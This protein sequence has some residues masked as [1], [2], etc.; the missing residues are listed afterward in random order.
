MSGERELIL[1]DAHVHL[2]PCFAISPF[3]EGAHESFK[4]AA[5]SYSSDVPFVGVLCFTDS[6]QS[7]GF[8]RLIDYCK[9]RGIDEERWKGWG[10]QPTMESTSVCLIAREDQTGNALIG[11]AG[12]QIVSQEHLEVLAIGTDEQFA[13]D[14]PITDV[15]CDIAQAGAIPIIPWGVGKWWNT[16]GRIIERLVQRTDLPDFF[17]G[18]SGN[19][20]AFWPQPSQFRQARALGIKNLPGSDPLPVRSDI[21]RVGSFGFALEGPLDWDRPVHDLKEKLL[22]PRTAVRPYGERESALRFVRNQV[23]MQ[24]HKLVGP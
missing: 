5:C 8:S 19:R 10:V 17:L 11:I 21:R 24:Y 15:I 12:R 13:Q 9:T 1:V 4:R 2:R 7:E 16:R 23:M 14:A 18:D 6:H 3:L 22:D 20:P